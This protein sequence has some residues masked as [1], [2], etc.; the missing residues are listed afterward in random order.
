[1]LRMILMA[2]A[3]LVPLLA[4]PAFAADGESLGERAAK[5]QPTSV[6]EIENTNRAPEAM[7]HQQGTIGA[8]GDATFALPASRLIGVDIWY[9]RERPAG[10]VTEIYLRQD[11]TVHAAVDLREAHLIL[12]PL[13]DLEVQT[14]RDPD[15]WLLVTPL[16]AEK[17]AQRPAF[18]PAG[19]PVDEAGL[20]VSAGLMGA[21]V[22]AEDERVGSV[23]DAMVDSQRGLAGLVVVLDERSVYV[24]ASALQWTRGQTDDAA[25]TLS[26][27]LS[28][29]DIEALPDYTFENV[30][31]EVTAPDSPAADMA[32][33]RKAAE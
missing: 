33:T 3:L 26:V 20:A 4:D 19:A 7:Q 15:D 16:T 8:R 11:G 1:M 9:G 13:S 10:S 27:S 17:L 23:E 18:D 14:G 29:E 30:A 6:E 22:S 5:N 28:R 25:A 31:E 32:R 2:S 21:A 24:P 12:L